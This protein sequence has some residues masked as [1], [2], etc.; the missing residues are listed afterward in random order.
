MMKLRTLCF[1][2]VWMMMV[3]LYCEESHSQNRGGIQETR[4][5]NVLWVLTKEVHAAAVVCTYV[6][7]RVGSRNELPGITGVSHQL[8]HMMFKGTRKAFPDP[9]YID[10]LIGRYGGQNNAGT[11][12]DSTSYFLLLPSDQ[13]DLALRIEAD[14]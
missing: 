14:R 3:G 11:E 6:W 2:L 9:G 1:C 12:S 7:Y 10:L 13:L 4:L 5:P 8:E